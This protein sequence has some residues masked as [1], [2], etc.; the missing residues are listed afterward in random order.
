MKPSSILRNRGTL[1]V[2]TQRRIKKVILD[3][4]KKYAEWPTLKDLE[5]SGFSKTEIE[6][7]VKEKWIV[8]L[9]VNMTSGAVVKVFKVADEN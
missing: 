5:K 7:G 2:F 3:H 1:D 4:R 8:Q 9:Y 6:L